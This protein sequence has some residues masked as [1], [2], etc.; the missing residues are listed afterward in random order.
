LRSV[1]RDGKTG[2][3]FATRDSRGLL[4]AIRRILTNSDLRIQMGIEARR[5]AEN[6]YSQAGIVNRLERYYQDLLSRPGSENVRSD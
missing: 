2:F 5:T 4:N 6:E 3:L 1:I